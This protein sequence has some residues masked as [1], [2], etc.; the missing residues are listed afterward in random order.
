M[1]DEATKERIRAKL[2]ES[3]ERSLNIANAAKA[4]RIEAYV[5]M[6]RNGE[7]LPPLPSDEALL[8]FERVSAE[9]EAEDEAG[10]PKP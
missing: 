1:N 3:R 7:E 10:G 9:D 8:V 2:R 4:E 6:V 5:A